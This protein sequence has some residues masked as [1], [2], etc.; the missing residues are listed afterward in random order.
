MVSMCSLYCI[1]NYQNVNASEPK[2]LKPHLRV[3]GGGAA[4]EHVLLPL[5]SKN[6]WGGPTGRT[7]RGF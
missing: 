3:T 1:K 4:P 2:L 5:G 7:R 6:V